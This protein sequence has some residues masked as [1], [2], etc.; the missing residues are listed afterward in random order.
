MAEVIEHVRLVNGDQFIG[1]RSG[2]MAATVKY[3]DVVRVERL[4]DPDTGDVRVVMSL[5]SSISDEKEISIA[6]RHII[7]RTSIADRVIATYTETIKGMKRGEGLQSVQKVGLEEYL[8]SK[9]LSAF[10]KISTKTH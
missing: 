2:K 4:V 10:P 3:S 7:T 8:L 6:Q 1:K 5:F 9:P